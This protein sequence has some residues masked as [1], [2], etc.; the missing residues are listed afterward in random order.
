VVKAV[1]IKRIRCDSE[2]HFGVLNVFSGLAYVEV[3][4]VISGCVYGG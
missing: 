2:W 3:V 1:R 4:Q